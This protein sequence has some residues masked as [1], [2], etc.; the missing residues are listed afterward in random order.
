MI[1]ITYMVWILLFEIFLTFIC[2]KNDH[3]I[4]QLLTPSGSISRKNNL[5]L[6]LFILKNNVLS[7]ILLVKQVVK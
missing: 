2:K 7:I 4:I 6:S 1:K 3:Q 5:D